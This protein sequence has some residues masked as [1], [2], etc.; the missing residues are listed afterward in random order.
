MPALSTDAGQNWKLL[1]IVKRSAGV[2]PAGCPLGLPS[3]SVNGEGRGARRWLTPQPTTPAPG[4]SRAADRAGHSSRRCH[5]LTPT[6][7]TAAVGHSHGRHTKARDLRRTLVCRGAGLAPRPTPH[8]PHR[9]QTVN[10][11]QE[12]RDVVAEPAGTRHPQRGCRTRRPARGLSS[13]AAGRDPERFDRPDTFD[14][15]RDAQGHLTFRHGPH[16]CLGA[17]LA[18]LEGRIALRALLEHAPG[19]A[20]D[21]TPDQLSRRNALIVRSL[22]PLPVCW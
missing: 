11:R 6:A 20:L 14:I 15:R 12:L 17:P 4:P 9:R 18:R 1:Q 16:H 2:G 19:L 13:P 5:T 22:K 10:Q 7:A 3:E 8:A 21:T